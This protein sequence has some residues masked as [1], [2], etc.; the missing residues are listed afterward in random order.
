[1]NPYPQDSYGQPQRPQQGYVASD[2]LYTAKRRMQGWWLVTAAMFVLGIVISAAYSSTL[3]ASDNPYIHTLQPTDITYV[4]LV[5]GLVNGV[6]GTTAFVI[7]I[8]ATADHSRAKRET[9]G[10]Y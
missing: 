4:L 10:R 1:M 5:I 8:K 9:Y 6:A 3:V 2:P 7:A